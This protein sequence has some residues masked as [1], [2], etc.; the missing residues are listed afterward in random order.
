MPFDLT[1]LAVAAALL[2]AAFVKG[3]SG[4]GFPLIATPMVALL[5]DIRTAVVILIIPNLLMDAAQIFRG[6]LSI[7]IFRRFRW[8]LLWTILGV[9]LGTKVLVMLPAWILNLTLGATVLAFVAWS[10]LRVEFR[11]S[12]RLE[13]ILSPLVGIVGGFLN[14]MTNAAGPVPAIYLYSLK[15]PKVEFIKSIATIF[16]VTKLSQLAA[17]STWNLFD[18]ARLELSLGVTLFV[19]AGFYL[20]LK[21]QDRVNQ[22][23]F[24]RA[25]LALL[26]AIG[27][28][29]IWRAV[30]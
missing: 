22:E 7:A 21:A 27:V 28:A 10:L 9:F 12:P 3:T 1:T 23:T 29:L 6:S 2:L 16:I 30:R 18:R 25:L 15:L 4:M 20:G 13:K 5:L 26:F 19:L 24:N 11:I 17:V 8:L 14:G